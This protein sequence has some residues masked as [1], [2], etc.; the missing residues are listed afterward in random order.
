MQDQHKDKKSL[1]T[2]ASYS[3]AFEARL[4]QNRLAVEGIQAFVSGE[5]LVIIGRFYS[6]SPRIKLQVADTDA[7]KAMAV[8]SEIKSQKPPPSPARDYKVYGA[9]KCP[10]CG[11]TEMSC[12]PFWQSVI[13]ASLLLLCFP[14]P[15][16]KSSWL[17]PDCGY[18]EKTH[19]LLFGIKS[20]LI[21]AFLVA[22]VL[23]LVYIYAT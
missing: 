12:G 9:K 2:I 23:G 10:R 21:L 6:N 20:L 7:E 19:P 4:A 22:I 3:Q 14:V 18:C 16:P 11:S 1:V 5:H 13:F 15:T 17:C 8:L